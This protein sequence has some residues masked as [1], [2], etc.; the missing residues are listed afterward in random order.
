MAYK[1]AAVISEE[2]CILHKLQYVNSPHFTLAT[3]DWGLD[4][5]SRYSR[6]M[7]VGKFIGLHAKCLAFPIS[8]FFSGF[9][10]V[11]QN[12]ITSNSL[13]PR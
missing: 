2:I 6:K 8:G 3:R 7:Q 10:F 4:A 13:K 12:E 11:A 1:I 5:Q 9:W